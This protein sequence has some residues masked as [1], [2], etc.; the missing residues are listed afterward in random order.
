M[1]DEITECVVATIPMHIHVCSFSSAASAVCGE[2][3]RAP[4]GWGGG[5]FSRKKCYVNLNWKKFYL[6]SCFVIRNNSH[7]W[8]NTI[9]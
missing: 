4:F 9:L 5:S 8:E 3:L 6:L 7:I 1:R 2:N